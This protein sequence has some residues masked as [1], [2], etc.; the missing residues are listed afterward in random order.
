MSLFGFFKK[1]EAEKE[2][3]KYADSSMIP[4]NERQLYQ[5]DEYY[6][7]IV[8]DPGI[9]SY[10][11]VTFEDRK[12]T[13]V[14]SANGLYVAEILLLDYCCNV[15]YPISEGGLYP[16]FWW[17][18]YGIR[19]VGGA[20]RS[21]E[22]RGFIHMGENGKYSLTADG[23]KELKDNIYVPYMHSYPYT[24][25][26]DTTFGPEFNV[27]SINKLLDRFDKSN[28]KDVIAIEENRVKEAKI[29]EIKLNDRP[30]KKKVLTD[31]A[32]T[33]KKKKDFVTAFYYQNKVKIDLYEF[34]YSDLLKSAA[35][36]ADEKEKLQYLYSAKSQY[37]EY[38]NWCNSNKYGKQYFE[39]HDSTGP[40]KIS[41]YQSLLKEIAELEYSVNVIVPTILRIIYNDG[42][43]KQADIC[44]KFDVSRE[45]VLT[46]IRR[47][48]NSGQLKTEKRGRYVYLIPSEERKENTK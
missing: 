32:E 48:E 22:S 35:V 12:T 11:V 30:D 26:E 25:M 18:K 1:K 38:R 46:E 39:E 7:F 21:L 29:Q 16:G 15:G 42:G 28:W 37:E 6:T 31:L 43:A 20:L 40:H 44:K 36:S 47:L 8:G 23:E 41:R 27:W 14:P 24:T 13:C 2:S 10:K 5:P 3:P 4:E 34:Y 19:D 9:M 45:K 17:F 33:H